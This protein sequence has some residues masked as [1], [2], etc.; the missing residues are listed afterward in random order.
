MT[1]TDKRAFLFTTITGHK[2]KMDLNL[3][4]TIGNIKKI[5]ETEFGFQSKNLKMFYLNQKLTNNMRLSSIKFVKD[6]PILLHQTNQRFGPDDDQT[7][8]KKILFPSSKEN[9]VVNISYI[10]KDPINFAT[11]VINLK[12]IGYKEQDCVEALRGSNYDIE[13][14]LRY[15]E[16]LNE[17]RARDKEVIRSNI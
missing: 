15:L 11:L 9:I 16:N 6:V 12:E 3:S 8:Q 1:S 4:E 17:R 14:A 2:I 5:M 13:Q 7:I 10:E